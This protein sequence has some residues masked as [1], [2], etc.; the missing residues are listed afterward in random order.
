M[1]N[2]F[3]INNLNEIQHK[4]TNKKLVPNDYITLL[5]KELN[6]NQRIKNYYYFLFRRYS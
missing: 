4:L 6:L 2:K 3:S 5:L 1:S